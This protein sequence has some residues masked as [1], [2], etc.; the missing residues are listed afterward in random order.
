MPR[1]AEYENLDE[2][3]ATRADVAVEIDKGV[4]GDHGYRTM[5]DSD[6]AVNGVQ[7]V[8]GTPSLEES[9]AFWKRSEED[10]FIT[11]DEFYAAYEI[12]QGRLVEL[13][14]TGWSRRDA[15]FDFRGEDL[16]GDGTQYLELA[17]SSPRKP[18]SD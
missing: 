7:F 14:V 5:S 18:K 17:R 16:A 9:A 1:S 8:C 4:V 10:P 15:D 2:V 13:G 3:C 12:F 11:S 6:H